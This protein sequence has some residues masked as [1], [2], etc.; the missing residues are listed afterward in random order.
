MYF[1]RWKNSC[2]YLNIMFIECAIGSSHCPGNPW[3]LVIF[4]SLCPGLVNAGLSL[5]KYPSSCQGQRLLSQC[6]DYFTMLQYLDTV[7]CSVL[8]CKISFSLVAV[9][10]STLSFFQPPHALPPLRSFFFNSQLYM[11]FLFVGLYLLRVSSA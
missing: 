1:H 11:G 7:G 4:F 10:S 9:I 5:A 2:N 8:S 6:S 3:T